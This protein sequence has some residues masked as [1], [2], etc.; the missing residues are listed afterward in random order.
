MVIPVSG[1]QIGFVPDVRIIAPPI[2][3][4]GDGI[5][6]TR[7]LGSVVDLLCPLYPKKADICSALAHVCFGPIADVSRVRLPPKEKPRDI[8]QGFGV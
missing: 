6:A 7:K 3:M 1:R 8:A 2:I 5:T 4:A